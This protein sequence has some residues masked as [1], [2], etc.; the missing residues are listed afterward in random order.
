MHLQIA[1]ED[2]DNVSITGPQKPRSISVAPRTPLKK[3]QV[4]GT[5]NTSNT[6][7]VV[8]KDFTPRTL[9]LA[10]VSKSHVRTRT[11]FDEP[12]PR[13]NKISRINFAWKTIKESALASEDVEVRQAYKRATG[14]T[15]SKAKLM[16][17][18]S[19]LPRY[20]IYLCNERSDLIRSH[21]PCQ[22]HN[23][24]SKGEGQ[25]ILR[26]FRRCGHS[27]KGCR[28]VVKEF[29]LRLWR[30]QPQGMCFLSP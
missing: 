6:S 13:N 15:S 9:K 29:S 23:I 8:E 26:S 17:F 14:D 24:Q 12:F 28:V 3:K 20:I 27:Q 30:H 25:S 21:R 18:V 4:T 2:L 1:I 7:K 16:K 5:H 19:Y 10:L 22:Q 11:I